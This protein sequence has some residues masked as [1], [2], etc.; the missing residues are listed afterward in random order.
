MRSPMPEPSEVTLRFDRGTL[1]VEGLPESLGP[2]L[3]ALGFVF[4][5]RVARPRGPASAYHAAFAALYR[6]H[7]RGTLRL[8]DKARAYAAIDVR[9]R[10]ERAPRFY[11][12]EA[13]EAWRRAGRRGVVVLP[14]GAGK[15]HVAHLAVAAVGRAALVVVPTIDLMLQWH[16]GLRASTTLEHVGLLGG[17][18]HDLAPVTVTT[19]DSLYIHCERLGDQF[20][21][22]I[23]DEVHHL[24][25]PSYAQAA[26]ALIAPFRLGLTATPERPDGRHALID[27]LV[28]PIVYRKEIRELAGDFLAEYEVE[29]LRVAMTEEEREAYRAARE[30]YVGFLRAQRISMAARDGWA[31]FIQAAART[32][33]GR[34]AMRAYREQR[35]LALASTAKLELVESLLALHREDRAII[36]THDNAT[37]YELSRRLLLPTITHRTGARE[38][39]EILDRFRSGAYRVVVTSRVLNE[40]V[41]VPEANVAVVLSGSGTQ[42]E[43]VQRLGRVLR[44][45]DGK[46][47]RL[48]EIVTRDTMEEQVSERRREHDAFR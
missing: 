28:G 26:E 43:H 45:R 29:T 30:V 20:G 1:V 6:H 10:H 2:E 35:A 41:D 48:Y 23:F 4:D 12:A 14:T 24:P 38:R 39:A 11:Q 7:E 5:T 33:A 47:A 17:G 42:R 13:L 9:D 44:K 8:D 22:V 25:G 27:Q 34:R 16:A 36:F 40:G 19:Y 15:S 31:R 18:S 46:Q 32:P 3:A 21:L 37:V